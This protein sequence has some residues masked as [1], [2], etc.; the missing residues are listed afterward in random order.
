MGSGSGAPPRRPD[1]ADGS[2]DIADLRRRLGA[3]PVTVAMTTLPSRWDM[4]R[5][6]LISVRRQRLRPDRVV[7]CVP[8]RSVR[9]ARDYLIPSWLAG[10][11][12]AEAITVAEDLGP[13]TKLLGVLPAVTDPDA[14]IVTVDDDVAYH[15]QILEKLVDHALRCPDAAIGF[16]GFDA[17]RLIAEGEYDAYNETRPRSADPAVVDVLEGWAGVAY[18][19]RF[20]DGSAFDRRGFPDDVFF[21][22][23]VWLAGCLARRQIRR[24]VFRF[25]ARS[26]SRK[27]I[28]GRVWPQHGRMDASPLHMVPGF[29]DKNRRVAASFAAR[30]PGIWKPWPRPV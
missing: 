17:G 27:D 6:T 2:L 1:A 5:T 30:H 13:A 16:A 3:T 29:K 24:L 20:F 4:L 21:V 23:D 28:L 22:D 25:S 7:V 15:E 12:L 11:G 19:R 10:D 18:R 26:L 9:E 14:I 8:P